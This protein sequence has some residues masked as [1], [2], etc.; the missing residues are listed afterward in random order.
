MIQIT[1]GKK[2]V[3]K[4]ITIMGVPGV[5]KT[6][7]ASMF[8]N[9]LFMDVEGSSGHFDNIDR[10][11]PKTLDEVKEVFKE[12]MNLDYKTLVID[13]VD[14]LEKITEE[15]MLKRDNK[16][17]LEEYGYGK[18]YQLLGVEMFNLLQD[19]TKITKVGKDV[20]ILAHVHIVKFEEPDHN[21]AYDRYQMKTHKRV[22]PLIKEWCDALLFYRFETKVATRDGKKKGVGGK[23]RVIHCSGN[24]A[25]DAKNRFKLPEII[26]VD[27]ENELPNELEQLFASNETAPKEKEIPQESPKKTESVDGHDPF[28]SGESEESLVARCS[29]LWEATGKDEE[30]KR[31]AFE[32]VGCTDYIDLE[33]SELSDEQL[34]KLIKK[35]L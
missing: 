4:K 27:K 12:F 3:G 18:G 24:A 28:N 19:L 21:G 25:Y 34:E 35:L 8:P 20:V 13:T 16:K 10:V 22:E 30:A 2:K 5:G 14:W 11:E 31:K 6:T 17:N 23:D 7:L 26:N 15:F 1:K 33:F 9:P 29:R 32:W